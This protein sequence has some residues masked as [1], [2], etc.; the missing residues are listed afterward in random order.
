LSDFD[1]RD[2]IT[3]WFEEINPEDWWKGDDQ[4]DRLIKDRF[5]E[6]HSA[7][8]RCELFPWREMPMGRLA[9]V[10][11]LDQLSR[12]IYRGTPA[13]FAFDS[14]ALALAQEAVRAQAQ[15][16]FSTAQK[17]F[18]YMPFMHS[19]SSRIHEIAIGLFGEPGLERHLQFEL[20]HKF[21]IDRFGRYPHRNKIL[22]RESTPEEE[23]FLKQ[24][25]SSF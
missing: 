14:M 17:A 13:A 15:K 24:P 23:E 25:G 7:A 22:R 11:A 12:H 10:L 1:Y 21:I 19:E 8:S 18:L 20:R 4:F 2:L 16:H 6:V 9:E 5:F 3:F